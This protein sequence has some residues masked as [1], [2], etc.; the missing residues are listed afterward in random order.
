MTDDAVKAHSFNRQVEVLRRR[1]GA[2][3]FAELEAALSPESR[4][5]IAKPPLGLGW[6]PVH[7]STEL[8]EKALLVLFKGDLAEMF[9]MGREQFKGDMSTLYR[10]FMRFASPHT[11]ADRASAIFSTYQRGGT[12]MN[13]TA[14]EPNA[15]ELL[16][17]NAVMPNPAFWSYLRGSIHAVIEL[18]G[19]KRTEVKIISGGGR[20]PRALFRATWQ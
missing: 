8:L 3:R 13:C 19:V 20:D 15:V 14:K 11:L 6:L 10:V 17:E 5:L 18:S 12:T 7:R 1:V 16:V 2:A 9:E 4:A